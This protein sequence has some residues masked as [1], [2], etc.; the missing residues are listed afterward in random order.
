MSAF[1]AEKQEL[2]LQIA[3]IQ[4]RHVDACREEIQP[5][6]QE[7]GRLEAL[8]P[9]PRIAAEQL[10]RLQDIVFPKDEFIRRAPEPSP[11]PPEA[12]ET[13]PERLWVLDAA[14]SDDPEQFFW[15]QQPPGWD[16]PDPDP[17]PWPPRDRVTVYVHER[18]AAED[19]RQRDV[20]YRA[21]VDIRDGGRTAAGQDAASQRAQAA[22]DA[23]S[24]MSSPSE[25]QA[26]GSAGTFDQ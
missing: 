18:I 24:E 23:I 15:T 3:K 9:E 7:L 8:D 5:F 14:G 13:E 20:A 26:H 12:K 1:H 16:T 6:L 22:L 11:L 19:G 25:D 17:D 4:M 10:A 2:R 21:L